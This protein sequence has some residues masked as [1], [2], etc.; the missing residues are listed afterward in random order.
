MNQFKKDAFKEVLEDNF[1]KVLNKVAGVVQPAE[2]FLFEARA[3]R[4]YGDCA[5]LKGQVVM[6]YWADI[7]TREEYEELFHLAQ[8]ITNDAHD[9]AYFGHFL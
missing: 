5:E 4:L 9:L 3:M 6:A 8:D 1:V 7:L 2:K